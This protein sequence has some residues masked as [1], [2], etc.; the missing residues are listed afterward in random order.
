MPF[1]IASYNILAQAYIL[2]DRYPGVPPAFLDAEYRKSALM[3]HIAA[4]NAD[5]ICLQET[6]REMFDALQSHLHS[7]GYEGTFAQKTARV[8][9]CATFVRTDVLPLH[10]IRSHAYSD[11][12][13]KRSASGHVAL[14]TTLRWQ[15]RLV[16][17]ANTHLKWDPPGTGA[18]EQWGYR[19]ITQLLAQRS[20]LAPDATAWVI[21]GD[22]NVTSNSEVAD[23]L[24]QAGLLDAYREREYMR[25]CN[26]NNRARRIDFL[27]HTPELTARPFPLRAITD[28]TT[29][30]SS[31][32]PSDH[33]AIMAWFDYS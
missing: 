21:C 8:D 7:R 16:A 31:D 30:P 15:D 14:A 26:T 22:F 3:R 1:T 10:A 19:Q 25:T 23:A 4:L 9:G 11:G 5:V 12:G 20:L 6:E 27:F 17:V 28:E 32:E 18:D 13:N 2:P 29:L 33:L 24:R